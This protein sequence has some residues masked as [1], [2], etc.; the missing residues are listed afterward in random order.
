M[1]KQKEN[2]GFSLAPLCIIEV[3]QGETGILSCMSGIS[4]QP[5]SNSG[6]FL[7]LYMRMRHLK[8]LNLRNTASYAEYNIAAKPNLFI[9]NGCTRQ[10]S[11]RGM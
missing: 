4:R 2:E 5:G 3:S 11:I 10:K 6:W 9:Q 1:N 8:K 7:M